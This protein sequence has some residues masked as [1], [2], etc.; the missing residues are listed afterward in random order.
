MS[1]QPDLDVAIVGGGISGVYSAMRLMTS[2][3]SDL[4]T[5]PDR[6]LNVTVFELSNRIGGRLLS[7]EPPGVPTT[8]VEVGGMRYTSEHKHVIGLVGLFGLSPIPFPVREPQNIAYLRGQML[9]MQDLT[10]ASKLPYTFH[11]DEAAASVLGEGF[12]AIAAERLLRTMTGKDVNLADVNWLD[13]AHNMEFEGNNLSDLPIRY[14]MQRMI[15]HEAYAF[16]VDTSGY[17]SILYT[18]SGAD[19]FPWNLADFG[20]AVTYSHLSEG[21]QEVPL[22]C[23]DAFKEAGGTLQMESRLI[24]FDEV[25]LDDDTK[26]VEFVMESTDTEKTRTTHV[27]RNLIL[28]MPRRSLE[29]LAPTGKVMD[30]SNTLVRD[31]IESVTP[32]PLFKLAMCYSNA[33]WET[34]PAIDVAA[35]DGPKTITKGESVTDL[36]VRQLYYWDTDPQ[37]G[38]AVVLIYDDGL[39]LSFW[40]GLRSNEVTFQ[41]TGGDAP[42][43]GLPAWS[44]FPAPKRMVDEAHRQIMEMHGVTGR[45]DIPAPYAAAYHDWGDDPYGGGANFWHVGV[46]SHE[47]ARA[48]VQP[49][50][51][52]HVY[53]CGE[54]YSHGQG[55]VEGA[56]ATAEDMLQHHLGL[57]PPSWEAQS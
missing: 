15:S 56:L 36:P 5:L 25:T 9:R 49:V 55:W 14:L 27:A 24:S 12:T 46:K 52:T 38:N 13:V 47:V 43:E 50:D 54:A 18:W 48:I 19:G 3:R 41:G 8:R 2:E 34:L 44:D 23:A 30:P 4:C 7:L 40:E 6:N 45:E 16:A 11:P 21:Y 22:R 1:K 28:A 42:G 33:W 57:L 10:D 29:M 37:T 31:L 32:I 35:A 26:G 51:K 17:D 53:I 20:G 39:A